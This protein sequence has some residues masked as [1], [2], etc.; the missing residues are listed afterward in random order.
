MYCDRYTQQLN[1]PTIGTAENYTQFDFDAK[2]IFFDFSEDLH[3]ML[4]KN[5]Y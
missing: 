5:Y 1:F 3:V 2:R 4:S